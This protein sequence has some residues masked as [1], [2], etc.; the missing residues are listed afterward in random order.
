MGKIKIKT[1]L[2]VRGN[3]EE[4]INIKTH[5]IKTDNKIVFQEDKTVVTLI[6]EQESLLL[7]RKN[8]DYTL[9]MRFNLKESWCIFNLEKMG[10][11]NLDLITNELLIEDG[12]INLNYSMNDSSYN[13][14]INYEVV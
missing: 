11:V 2:T 3:S 8:S 4:N 13:Y 1:K 14:L 5:G 6:L 9:K 12:I 7:Q 10:N